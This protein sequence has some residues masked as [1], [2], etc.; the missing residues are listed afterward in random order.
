MKN[1]E[2]KNFKL[3]YCKKELK[4]LLKK[5]IEGN[6]H[7]TAEAIYNNIANSGVEMD[8]NPK[9]KNSKTIKEFLAENQF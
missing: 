2:I 9:L 8:L 3:E 1:E 6:Y 5:L 7:L 4:I